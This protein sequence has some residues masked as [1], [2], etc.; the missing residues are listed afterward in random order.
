[1]TIFSICL[2]LEGKKSHP[3]NDKDQ[4]KSYVKSLG[5][6]DSDPQVMIGWI[7]WSTA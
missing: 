3:C 2:F 4:V 5:C 6:V 7:D 1:M